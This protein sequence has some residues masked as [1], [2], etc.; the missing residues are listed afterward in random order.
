[1]QKLGLDRRM[2]GSVCGRGIKSPSETLIA[3]LVIVA[4]GVFFLYPLRVHRG[5]V[6]SPHS[7]IIAQHL[8]LNPTPRYMTGG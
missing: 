2:L 6:Y 1:M 7:D 4:A 5:I 8:S 3:L